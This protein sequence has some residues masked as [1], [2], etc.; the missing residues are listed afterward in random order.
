MK[1]LW[2]ESY[3]VGGRD[4]AGRRY[5]PHLQGELG[6]CRQRSTLLV[7]EIAD[8]IGQSYNHRQARRLP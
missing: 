8:V 1:D 7:D 6:F 3:P 4:Q 2:L 5:R